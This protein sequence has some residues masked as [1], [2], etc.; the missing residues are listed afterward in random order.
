M[1][2]KYSENHKNSRKIPRDEKDMNN[3]NKAFGSHEKDFVA[4]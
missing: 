4:F 2:E 1:H 3:T